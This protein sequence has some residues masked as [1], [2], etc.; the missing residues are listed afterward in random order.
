MR[1]RDQYDFTISLLHFR[2]VVEGFEPDEEAEEDVSDR[3]AKLLN[4]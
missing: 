4:R 3:Y 2:N 1:N